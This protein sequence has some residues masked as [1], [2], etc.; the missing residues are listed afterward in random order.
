[1]NTALAALGSD[2]EAVLADVQVRTNGTALHDVVNQGIPHTERILSLRQQVTERGV[3]ATGT[4]VVVT[5]GQDTGGA[6]LNTALID[7]TF[8]DLV[9]VGISADIDD[10]DLTTIGRNGSFLAPQPEDWADAFDEIADRVEQYPQ[11]AYLLAYCASANSGDHEVGIRISNDEIDQLWTTCTFNADVFGT[12]F[13]D[14]C[15]ADYLT[16][17]CDGV[18]CGGLFACGACANDA[19]CSARSCHEPAPVE[20]ACRNDLQCQPGGDICDDDPIV[21]DLTVCRGPLD[22]GAACAADRECGPGVGYC[23]DTYCTEVT[24]E[25]GDVCG[26]EDAHPA[27][28]CPELNCAARNPRQPN[29][30]Y[31]CK[32]RA[33]IG[34]ACAGAVANAECELGAYCEVNQQTGDGVCLPQ[35]ERSCEQ[36]YHCS[37]GECD[38]GYCVFRGRCGFAWDD[39]VIR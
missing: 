33:R 14:V 31:V 39:R 17:A 5:D 13:E 22:P 19:C 1:V 36:D 30:G 7:N 23:L 34:D 8:V 12:D 6:Q 3:L 2:T 25:N 11:R 29:Q 20:G 16:G 37:S 15:D 4:L 27:A 21:V 26:D 35:N 28:V 9:S 18:E 24:R 10:G 32:P 38:D